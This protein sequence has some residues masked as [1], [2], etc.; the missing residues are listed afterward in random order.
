[1]LG[2]VFLPWAIHIRRYK[3]KGSKDQSILFKCKEESFL[4]DHLLFFI[5]HM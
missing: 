5:V 1:M 3:V 2:H 4:E